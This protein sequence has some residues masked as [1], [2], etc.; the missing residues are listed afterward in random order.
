MQPLDDY[1]VW[2]PVSHEE[3][4]DIGDFRG[5][6]S[7]WVARVTRVSN[8]TTRPAFVHSCGAEIMSS[9]VNINGADLEIQNPSRKRFVAEFQEPL[10][11]EAA[12][13]HVNTGAYARLSKRLK[14]T[15]ERYVPV[16]DNAYVCI[17]GYLVSSSWITRKARPLCRRSC[18]RSSASQVCAGTHRGRI[19]RSKDAGED[20]DDW[21]GEWLKDFLKGM[22]PADVLDEVFDVPWFQKVVLCLLEARRD[23]V[24]PLMKHM[25]GVDVYPSHAV[26]DIGHNRTDADNLP[27]V[28]THEPRFLWWLL[29]PE[30]VDDFTGRGRWRCCSNCVRPPRQGPRLAPP[31]V[32]RRVG[33]RGIGDLKEC[34]ALTTVK[35]H[36]K[37]FAEQRRSSCKFRLNTVPDDTP[38]DPVPSPAR[39]NYTYSRRFS[40]AL[41]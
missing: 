19:Q 9:I 13:G 36:P 40:S 41:V 15:Y 2:K 33:P 28:L 7:T 1:V 34:E 6:C 30:T 20:E 8:P 5:R 17:Y 16:S 32:S 22:F 21:R 3:I 29:N 18:A 14:A 38:P 23:L 27:K 4:G 35:F 37:T 11:Q 24:E 25:D 12:D 26:A 39:R 31:Q 10:D